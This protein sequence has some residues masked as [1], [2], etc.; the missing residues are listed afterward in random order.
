MFEPLNSTSAPL[1]AFEIYRSK[2]IRKI[3]PNPTFAETLKLLDYDNAVREVVTRHSN[4]LIFS[5]AQTYSGERPKINLVRLKQYLDSHVNPGFVDFLESGAKFLNSVWSKQELSDS[6]FDDD[7]KNCIRFLNA[8]RHEAAMPVIMRYYQLN[9]GDVPDVVKTIVAFYALWR[10]AFPTNSLP[11]IYRGLLSSG[12][13]DNI[14]YS[15]GV[16][17]SV[18]DLKSYF[19]SKL[20]IRLGV[21]AIG[22]TY[23]DLW[24]DDS[25]QTFLTYESLKT[26]CRLFIF[27]DIGQSIKSNLVP[28]DPWTVTDDIEHIYASSI[29]PSIQGVHK[30]GNL[31]FLPPTINRSIQ[32][33]AWDDKKEV[34]QLLGSTSK[35]NPPPRKF[36]DGRDLPISVQNYLA[37][38]Q[39]QAMAHL[40]QFISEPMWGDNQIDAR[41]KSMLKRVWAVLY[42]K[43]LN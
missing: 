11:E 43:W 6:W 3:F 37:S 2:T 16:I 28:D 40:N 23:Q 32:N 25:K 33:M 18:P 35:I 34:Y 36:A 21:P 24:I 15:G 17:K 7:T 41:S 20:E 38:P 22:Q 10:P 4:Q 13:P 27:L 31:T 9:P 29:Q 1:T 12:S 30:I 26:I 8:S 14:A 42:K 39:S 19:R 5:C